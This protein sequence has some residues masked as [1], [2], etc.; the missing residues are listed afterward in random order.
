MPLMPADRVEADLSKAAGFINTC[1]TTLAPRVGN[2]RRILQQRYPGSNLDQR[3]PPWPYWL[4][5]TQVTK[6][7]PKPQQRPAGA[8]SA[9]PRAGLQAAY[10]TSGTGQRRLPD[11]TVHLLLLLI[12]ETG[13]LQLHCLRGHTACRST[14]PSSLPQR[15]LQAPL[16][17]RNRQAERA[18]RADHALDLAQHV[19]V[20]GLRRRLRRFLRQQ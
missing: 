12:A 15:Y 7:G 17:L 2:T 5:P 19:A 20:P 6:Q 18:G 4:L 3:P 11:E 16:N 14:A 9:A 10:V 13:W 8:A 1:H